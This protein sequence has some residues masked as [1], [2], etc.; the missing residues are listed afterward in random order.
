[1]RID[2]NTAFDQMHA[3][4]LAARNALRSA[5]H[6]LHQ[7]VAEW[8]PATIPDDFMRRPHSTSAIPARPIWR[9]DDE[10]VPVSWAEPEVLYAD[11]PLL[12]RAGRNWL[13]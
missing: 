3:D 13:R 6:E 1:M 8:S 12:R 11:D 9:R 2:E 4:C 7:G 10:S 5:F